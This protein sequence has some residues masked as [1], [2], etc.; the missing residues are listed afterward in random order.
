MGE[1]KIATDIRSLVYMGRMG[2][3]DCGTNGTMG[4]MGLMGLW[5]EWDYETHGT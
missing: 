3:W 2:L 5:D 4:R 1:N